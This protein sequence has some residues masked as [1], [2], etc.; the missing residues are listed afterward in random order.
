MAH[1]ANPSK[2]YYISTSFKV[3]YT[4]LCSQPSLQLINNTKMS[5]NAY[6]KRLA[7]GWNLPHYLVVRDPY[8][9]IESFFKDKF[10]QTP[11]MQLN[12]YAQLQHC[13]QIFCPFLQIGPH[14]SPGAIRE[15]LLGLSFAQFVEQ[16]PHVYQ[17]DWHLLPQVMTPKVYY[18][19]WPV[20]PL[21]ITRTLKIE[22]PDDLRYLQ[23]ELA[24]DL[25]HKHNST[26]AIQ[27]EGAWSPNVRAIVNKLYRADFKKFGYKLV[28]AK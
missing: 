24:I 4:L 9:R 16:L 12:E 15:K 28:D 25:S 14:D 11:L 2:G 13:Q 1:F 26:D 27:L 18:R 8:R 10:R 20:A 19:A 6:L 21:I 5:A 7:H 23:D 3:L 22:S 17:L